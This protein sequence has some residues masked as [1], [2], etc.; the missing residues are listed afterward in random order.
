MKANII[1]IGNSRGIRL[2]KSIIERCELKDTVE[3][4]VEG[5]TLIIR[6]AHTP[7]EGWSEAFSVMAE[8]GDDRPLDA[9]AAQE[10]EWDAAEWRW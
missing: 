10:S 3:L 9:D 6:P 2:P 5:N 8:R 7:R 1:R 4:E